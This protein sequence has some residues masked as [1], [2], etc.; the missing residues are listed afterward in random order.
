MHVPY[1]E[2]HFLPPPTKLYFRSIIL[3]FSPG[4]IRYQRRVTVCHSVYDMSGQILKVPK[5]MGNVPET[6]VLVCLCRSS[7]LQ[8]PIS[9]FNGRVA[10]KYVFIETRTETPLSGCPYVLPSHNKFITNHTHTQRT[11]AYMC[12]CA[13]ATCDIIMPHYVASA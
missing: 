6:C 7:A 3:I 11:H 4:G 1:N 13:C 10:C 12:L 2:L 9:R 5:D 8:L